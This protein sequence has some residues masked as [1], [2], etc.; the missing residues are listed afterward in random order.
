MQ[1]FLIR[2]NFDKVNTCF[3]YSD[4]LRHIRWWIIIEIFGLWGA[5]IMVESDK[6]HDD[7]ILDLNN[8]YVGLLYGHLSRSW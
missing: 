6:K 1:D 7:K 5:Y 8:K 3:F 2:N 4:L